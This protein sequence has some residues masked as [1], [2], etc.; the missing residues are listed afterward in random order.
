M[1]RNG[2]LKKSYIGK[3]KFDIFYES[4]YRIVQGFSKFNHKISEFGDQ[5]DNQ[6]KI[7]FKENIEFLMK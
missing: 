1:T 5:A 2:K 6:Y 7:E 4:F 3:A